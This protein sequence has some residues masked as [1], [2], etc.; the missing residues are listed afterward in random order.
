MNKIAF[1]HQ[2]INGSRANSE[3][4]FRILSAVVALM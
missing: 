4:D 2:H 3:W 1:N